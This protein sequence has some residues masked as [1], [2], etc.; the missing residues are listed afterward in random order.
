MKVRSLM[1]GPPKVP[2]DILVAGGG[3]GAGLEAGVRAQ[4]LVGVGEV[5]GAVELVGSGLGG[6]G[7]GEAGAAREVDG[8][9]C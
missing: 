5:A 1:M 8:E 7:G 9:V 3:D 4:V 2:L 6:D